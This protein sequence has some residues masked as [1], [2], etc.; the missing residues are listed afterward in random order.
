MSEYE[1]IVRQKGLPDV[2]QFVRSKTYGTLWR[3]MEKNENATV[4][5]SR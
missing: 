5:G 3:V 4:F 2:G 1:E